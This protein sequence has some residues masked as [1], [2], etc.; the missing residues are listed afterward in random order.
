MKIWIHK[1]DDVVL[2]RSSDILCSIL[3]GPKVVFYDKDLETIKT[4]ALNKLCEN[5]D[6]YELSYQL[7]RNDRFDTLVVGS[8]YA[9]FGLD[10]KLL[11]TGRNM[12]LGSQDIYL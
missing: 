10:M 3:K 6:Y 12:A 1:H 8:S 9:L 4:L 5:Y 11:P 7:Q 2:L